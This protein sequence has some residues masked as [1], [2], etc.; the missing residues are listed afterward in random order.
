MNEKGKSGKVS[1]GNT[2]LMP[3]EELL[4]T[5]VKNRRISIGIDLLEIVL[6]GCFVQPQLLFVAS[7]FRLCFL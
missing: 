7:Q 6:V 5:A 3:K 4:K 1:F 2:V